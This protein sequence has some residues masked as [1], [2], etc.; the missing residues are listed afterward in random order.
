MHASVTGFLLN[1][2]DWPMKA[3]IASLPKLRPNYPGHV[4]HP[5]HRLI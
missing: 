5:G 4:G 2:I 1:Q 3:F